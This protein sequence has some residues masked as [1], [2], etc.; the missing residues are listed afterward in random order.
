MTASHQEP[1]AA[2]REI[3]ALARRVAVAVRENIVDVW[4]R[5]PIPEFALWTTDPKPMPDLTSEQWAALAAGCPAYPNKPDAIVQYARPAVPVGVDEDVVE[6]LLE[7]FAGDAQDEFSISELWAPYPTKVCTERIALAAEAYA[8]FRAKGRPMTA[9]T[10]NDATADYTVGI[11]TDHEIARFRAEREVDHAHLAA[12]AEWRA[13]PAVIAWK[14]ARAAITAH[15]SQDAVQARI[16]EHAR[17]VTGA[18]SYDVWLS[19]WLR[20]ASQLDLAR[21]AVWHS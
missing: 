11:A 8:E 1:D 17:A 5:G 6:S 19:R 3:R 18:P 10:A 2:E 16:L 7:W 13:S 20:T 14:A 21:A 4:I 9:P 12:V 15:Q